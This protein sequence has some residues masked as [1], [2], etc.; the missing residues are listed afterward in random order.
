MQVSNVQSLYATY[1]YTE[2]YLEVANANFI[3]ADGTANASVVAVSANAVSIS[4]G[5]GL[6]VNAG[7]VTDMVPT[8]SNA[9]TESIAAGTIWYSNNHLYV[10]TDE[11]TIKRVALSTF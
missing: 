1:S 9:A 3:S 6:T 5:H 11:N 4:N 8:T 2:R 10:A 7:G